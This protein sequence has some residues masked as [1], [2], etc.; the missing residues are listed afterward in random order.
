MISIDG[1]ATGFDTSS[2]IEE[3]LQ[4]KQRPLQ[5]VEAQIEV[6]QEKKAGY[7]ELMAKLL[8]LQQTASNLGSEELFSSVNVTS[9]NESVLLASGTSDLSP[10]SY[11]F[12]VSQ[13]ASTSQF[14]STGFATRD[15]T[16]V[17]AGT[18]TI[19]FGG[20]ALDRETKLEDL[21]GGEGVRRG[22]FQVTDRSGSTASVDISSALTVQDVLDAI[23]SAS[24]V[25]VTARIAETGDASPGE[26]IVIEDSSGGSGTL[27]VEDIGSGRAAS[28]LGIDGSAAAALLEGSDIVNITEDT[29]L[30]FLN[31]GN[32]IRVQSGIDLAFTLKNGSSFT[33]DLSSAATVSDLLAAVNDNAGNEGIT[34]SIASDGN[35]FTVSDTS[36]VSGTTTISEEGS[37]VAG[38]DLGIV[39]SFTTESQAGSRVLAGMNTALLRELNGGSGVSAGSISVTDRAGTTTEIDLSAA[40]TVQDVIELI[41]TAAESAGVAV[42]ASLNSAR[43]GLKIEDA[44]GGTGDLIV[45]EVDAGRT[46]SDLG[47]LNADGIASSEFEGADLDLRYISENTRLDTLNGGKGIYEG[48]IRITDRNGT[49]FTVNLGQEETIKQVLTDING[50]ASV[51]GSDVTASINESGNGILLSAP[52]GTGT[53]KVED[54]GGGT[55]AQDLGIAASVSAGE[56]D[57]SFEHTVTITDSMTLEDVKNEIESLDVDLN[58]SI[59]NDGS[60]NAPYRLFINGRNGG[61]LGGVLLHTT[62]TN[63]EFQQTAQARD[64][65]VMVGEDKGANPL[66]V[67]NATN[68]FDDVIPGLNLTAL[69]TSD[70]TVRVSAA[71]DDDKI[72][73]TIDKFVAAYNEIVDSINAKTAYNVETEEAGL[74]L[75]DSTMRSV[76]RELAFSITKAIPGNPA[77]LNVAGHVGIEL[78]T[79]GKLIFRRSEL[80]EKLATDRALVESLFTAER[81]L[82]DDTKLSSFRN[83]EGVRS[84]NGQNDFTVT[85]RDGS[86]FTVDLDGVDTVEKLLEAI[87]DA[88]GNSTV[89][90]SIA[91]GGHALKLTD[92]SEGGE[93]FRVTALNASPAFNDLGINKSA[94]RSGGG[95]IT[96][97]SV[98]V[99]GD[100]G[101][102]RR[103]VENIE[104]MVN[105]DNGTLQLGSE[106]FGKRIEDLESRIESMEETIA[107][108]EERLRNEFAQLEVIMGQQQNMLAQLNAVLG[109]ASSSSSGGLSIS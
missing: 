87:N 60:A 94:D 10:G 11:S 70:S 5:L 77:D 88:D 89:T 41:N 4:Y 97:Y 19:E 32:G 46:A 34:L 16:P 28:D 47:I 37:G 86:S 42:E 43:D 48:S 53:F 107:N 76:L 80:S 102:G 81:E 9:S 98:D 27:A 59:V 14:A 40:E 106:G 90:A 15:D 20:S 71:T 83:G 92:T 95:V 84:V 64:A 75:G 13:L 29:R 99:S 1:L 30:G 50:A 23:N 44:S 93:S 17:G 49:T 96:G 3:L 91:S 104:D 36:A 6:E 54:I 55:A 56:I 12:R 51:A 45:A 52:S 38:R 101:L 63:L 2:I 31:D 7:E 73:D 74:F 72:L 58:V 68:S 69:D 18:L 39:G 61:G 35:G 67:R 66:I 62:G 103:L 100:W 57:G 109:G 22:V 21:N 85:M 108:E 82:A 26:A 33:V 78:S 8:W 65:V 79:K 25:S 24:G 105:V